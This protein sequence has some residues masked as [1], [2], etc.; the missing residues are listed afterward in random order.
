MSYKITG[1]DIRRQLTGHYASYILVLFIIS[2]IL[3]FC[4][5]FCGTQLGW[6]N[7]LSIT[8]IVLLS[9]TFIIFLIVLFKIIRIKNHYVF[10]RYGSAESIAESI[11]KGLENPCYISKNKTNPFTLIITDNFIVST[12]NYR[13][14]LELKNARYMQR[15]VV[16]EMRTVVLSENPVIS[17]AS[18]AGINH[19][20]RKYSNSPNFDFLIIWDDKGMRYEYNIR[21]DEITRIMQLLTELAPQ[22]EIK[23]T[24]PL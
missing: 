20:A 1:K 14:Y 22:I 10:Q 13:Y 18:T 19:V 17:V 7:P 11:S 23:E 12:A 2:A 16:P 8:G 3:G 6:T 4:T 24:K 5:V 15:T 21:Q 9:I